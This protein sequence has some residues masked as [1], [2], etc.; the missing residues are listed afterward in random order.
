MAAP[1]G[2]EFWKLR[3]K[4][5]RDKLFKT[6][7]LLWEAAQEYF[8]WCIDHPLEEEQLVKYKESYEKAQVSKMRAFTIQGLC[9]YLDCNPGYFNEFEQSTKDDVDFSAITTRIRSIIFN[10]KFEGAAAGLLNA[11]IIARDLSLVDKKENSVTGVEVI[12]I[13]AKDED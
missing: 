4:H 2:N 5:G 13:K 6:P 12:Q 10:Q 9:L 3:S 8:Q 11:N 1:K 7:E